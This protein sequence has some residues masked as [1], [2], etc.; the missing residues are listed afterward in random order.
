ME[1]IITGCHASQPQPRRGI[2]TEEETPSEYTC[3]L[4]EFDESAEVA[5]GVAEFEAEEDR[6]ET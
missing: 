3:R 1:I 6:G 4:L 2:R 5:S